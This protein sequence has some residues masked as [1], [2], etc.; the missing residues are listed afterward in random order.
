[1]KILYT[2]KDDFNCDSCCAGF[3][4]KESFEYTTLITK[5]LLK[6]CIKCYTREFGKKITNDI[7]EKHG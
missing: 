4:R 1:M 3:Y 7:K 6:T 5:S 2:K